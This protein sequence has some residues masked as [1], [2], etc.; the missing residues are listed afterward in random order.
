MF[1]LVQVSRT[2]KRALATGN[3]WQENSCNRPDARRQNGAA[4]F[5][6]VTIGAPTG[7]FPS[8]FQ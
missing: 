7:D 5:P 2:L 3:Q 8:E 6:A 4:L 1:D